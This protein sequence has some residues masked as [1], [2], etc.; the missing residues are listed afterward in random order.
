MTK[1]ERSHGTYVVLARKYR[2]QKFSEVIGQKTI[3]RE[4]QE[5]VKENKIAHAF[6]FF[7]PRGSGKTS[8]ARILSKSLNCEK[9]P[10]P[11]PCDKCEFCGEIIS[12]ASLDFL[13]IDGAS[14]RGIDEIRSLREN[15]LLR[16]A[17]SRFK[18]YLIDEVHML[19]TEAFNALLKTLE[20]P[21]SYVKFIFATTSPEKIPQTIVS[22]CRKY[23]FKPLKTEEI[24][25]KIKLILKNENWTIDPRAL[26]RIISAGSGSLR[27]VLGYLD[28][29]IILSKERNITFELTEEVLGVIKSESILEII[30]LL[31]T[32]ETAEAL[33]IFHDFT[34]QGKE[35]AGFLDEINRN[36]RM[37]LFKK[38]NLHLF[39]EFSID[40]KY[41]EKIS[42]LSFEQILKGIETTLAIKEKSKYE[43]LEIIYGEI[44]IIR[45]S[46]ILRIADK[47]KNV[48]PVLEKRD[49]ARPLE[50]KQISQMKTEEMKT[51]ILKKSEDVISKIDNVTDEK[52]KEILNEIKKKKR[53]LE[54]CLRAG[55]PVKIEN[56]CLY[57]G[58]PEKMK[59]HYSRAQDNDNIT[60]LEKIIEKI[61]GF[62][63][64]ISYFL[65]KEDPKTIQDRTSSIKKIVDFFDGEIVKME[66]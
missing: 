50:N 22:R 13:E 42:L 6:L 64:N 24:T 27:D 48:E 23:Q 15:V 59:F 8:V 36:L 37:M 11:E 16:P 33:R 34:E 19:T 56:N 66:E 58:F 62:H 44:L 46:G 17:K 31:C 47:N 20:E 63:Y 40:E 28:Q 2:P 51:E 26:E 7:G 45:L 49:H 35:L 30:W 5:S 29:L 38:L 1:T 12:G 57:I 53:T 61:L 21:P 65:F 54:A 32:G 14:N 39:P 43:P 55:K 60:Y 41:S 25:E 18:I 3:I 10:L 9:G 52:W 4:L